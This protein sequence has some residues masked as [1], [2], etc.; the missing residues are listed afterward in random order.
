MGSMVQTLDL[1]HNAGIEDSELAYL[2]QS[3]ISLSKSSSKN[4][5]STLK[6]LNLSHIGASPSA[7]C[8][9]I[10]ALPQMTRL[11]LL[12][13]SGN[14]IAF[15]CADALVT[16]LKAI[17]SETPSSKKRRQKQCMDM[18][19][20]QLASQSSGSSDELLRLNL[21]ETKLDELTAYQLCLGI[22]QHSF[23]ECLDL[24][25]NVQLNHSF[26]RTLE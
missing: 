12:D 20:E 22:L 6:A 13:L 3:L 17:E 21:S 10:K 26:S 4:Q 19:P 1:S 8:N 14:T 5:L 25:K 18:S 23:I 11:N 7:L 24:S 15:F 9:F 16:A 2:T